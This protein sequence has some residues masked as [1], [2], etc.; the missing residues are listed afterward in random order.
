NFGDFFVAQTFE[1]AQNHRAAEDIGNLR[2]GRLHSALNFERGELIERRS[3][4]VFNFQRRVAFFGFSVNRNVLLK[5]TLEP[6]AMIE[7]LTNRDAIEPRLQRTAA[8]EIANPFERLEK[9]FLRGVGGVGCVPEHAENQVEDGGVV[10][11]DQPVEGGFRAGLKL[12]DELG[13]V[14]APR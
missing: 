1:I 12:A 6:A 4:S 14:T 10:V 13:F 3:T 2:E 5:V 11:R 7:R 9:N 8:E